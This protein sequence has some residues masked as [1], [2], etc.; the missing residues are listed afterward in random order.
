MRL[1]Q[2]AP[3]GRG[4]KHVICPTPIVSPAPSEG[5]KAA[6]PDLPAN[7]PC[8][9]QVQVKDVAEVMECKCPMGHT[10]Y[11]VPSDIQENA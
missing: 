3:E 2:L 10:F 5:F 6:F 7:T 4:M 8:G 1:L 11:A 9:M